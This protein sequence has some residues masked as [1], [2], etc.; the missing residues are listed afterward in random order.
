M[1]KFKILLTFAA[2][3]SAT[4]LALYGCSN[5]SDNEKESNNSEVVDNSS[6]NNTTQTN[7]SSTECEIN[8]SPSTTSDS[9]SNSKHTENTTNNSN[10]SNEKNPNDSSSTTETKE[11]NS[12]ANIPTKYTKEDISNDAIVTSD[13]GVKY[14]WAG[15]SSSLTSKV[16]NDERCL[17]VMDDDC[18]YRYIG[19]NTLNIYDENN[20]VIGKAKLK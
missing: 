4:T 6:E 19:L 17:F 18:N 12:N 10:N 11:T 15:D 1:K 8:N 7:D 9:Q 2:I 16:I 5:S 14:G 20:N 13:S 3:L